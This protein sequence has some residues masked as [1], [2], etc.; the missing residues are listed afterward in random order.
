MKEIYELRVFERYAAR[1]L[2][3]TQGVSIANGLGRLVKVS[4]DEETF[5]SLAEL[6]DRVRIEEG[7][8]GIISAWRV[9]RKYSNAEIEAAQLF[10][11]AVAKTFEPAGEECGTAY[12][13]ASACSICGSGAKQRTPLFLPRRAI[14]ASQDIART[15]AGEIVVS[16]R[17]RD[18]AAQLDLTGADFVPIH[19]DRRSQDESKDWF[20][21]VIRG[22]LAEVSPQT[23][24]GNGP[25]DDDQE[26]KYR[27]PWGDLIGLNLLSEVSIVSETRDDADVFS[28]RQFVGVRRGLL[29]PEKVVLASRRLY[30]LIK[31]ERLKGFEFEVAYLD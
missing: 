23:R 28:S 30:K 9:K 7:K 10:S 27:C 18:L 29:R 24:A 8:P 4:R 12:D 31:S 13:E 20:Q 16:R 25:F 17:F 2:A 19:D 3:E 6:D 15:I 14:P 26:G 22:D 11:L 21:L 1:V 5:Q